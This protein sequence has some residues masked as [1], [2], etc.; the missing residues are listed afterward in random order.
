MVAS[1]KGPVAKYLTMVTKY[2]TGGNHTLPGP[3]SRLFFAVPGLLR[4][5][6]LS[7]ETIAMY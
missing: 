7:V 5:A 6:V 4:Q 3:V 1:G 2:L